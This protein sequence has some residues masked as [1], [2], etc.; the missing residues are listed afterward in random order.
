MT[1]RA[2]AFLLVCAIA[3]LALAEPDFA[4]FWADFSAAAKAGDQAKVRALTKFPF[5]YDQKQRGEDGFSAIWKGL[6]TPKARACLGKGKPVKDQ[7]NYVLFCGEVG[8]Y[9]EKTPAG[10]QFTEIG[11][12]D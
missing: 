7:E 4:P 6:F 8:F 12:N 2:A 10:W 11:A 9:F 1:L 3:T 5:L